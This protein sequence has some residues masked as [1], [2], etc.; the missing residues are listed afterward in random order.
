MN[1]S[2]IYTLILNEHKNAG[3]SP[4]AVAR[5]LPLLGVPSCSGTSI[6]HAFILDRR[7]RSGLICIKRRP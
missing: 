3:D 7:K 4:G 1:A 5:N 6:F 2:G